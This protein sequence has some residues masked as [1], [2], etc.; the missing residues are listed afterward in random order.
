VGKRKA[1]SRRIATNLKFIASL[2]YTVN[3]Y[4]Y[5]GEAEKPEATQDTKLLPQRPQAVPEGLENHWS[6]ASLES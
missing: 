6:L 3:D 4:L 2:G 5:T 1:G